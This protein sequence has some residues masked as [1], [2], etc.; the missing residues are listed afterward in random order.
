MHLVITTQHK[1]ADLVA[2]TA[3]KPTAVDKDVALAMYHGSNTFIALLT[4][5]CVPLPR[6]LQPVSA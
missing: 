5:V 4:G 1:L 6:A 2:P 3:E